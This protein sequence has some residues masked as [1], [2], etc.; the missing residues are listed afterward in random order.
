MKKIL[1]YTTVNLLLIFMLSSCMASTSLD[2]R[3]I[4]KTIYL[5]EDNKG[6]VYAA[7]IIYTCKPSANTADVQGEP[8]LY[9]GQGSSIVSAINDAQ[10]KQNKQPFYE[11]NSTVL[12][13]SGTFDNISDYL[14]YFAAEEISGTDLSVFLTKTSHSEFLQMQNILTDIVQISEGL[15]GNFTNTA[16][17]SVK[18]YETNFLQNEFSGYLPV[19]K[20]ED[21]TVKGVQE[22][23]LFNDEIPLGNVRALPM[24]MMLILSDKQKSLQTSIIVNGVETNIKTQQISI[25]Y[26]THKNGELSV[27]ISGKLK[28]VTQNGQALSK[29]DELLACEEFN[30][31]IKQAANLIVEI[32]VNNNNDIFN[33]DN[34]MYNNQNE[35][36]ENVNIISNFSLPA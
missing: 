26:E 33:Y 27:T 22:L 8:A 35:L 32:T 9:S 1:L 28:S 23:M 16:N 20:I 17:K 24:E 15:G 19:L 14:S 36:C 11:Q 2:D 7:L 18:I 29:Q 5:N 10:S 30:K 31:T 6:T 21:S 34:L 25:R 12:L 4:V 3:A 13:G